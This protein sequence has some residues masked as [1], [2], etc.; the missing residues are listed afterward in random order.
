MS[1][2]I[3]AKDAVIYAIGN[4]GL[5]AAALLLLPA[6]A[7]F[8]SLSDFGLWATLQSIIQIMLILMNVGMRETSVRFTKE[9]EDR[10]QLGYLLG[11]T[12]FIVLGGALLVTALSLGPLVPVFRSILH[13]DNVR[14]LALLTCAGALMQALSIHAMTYYRACNQA[15]RYMVGGILGA[16]L[17]FITTV[18]VLYGFRL[19]IRGVLVAYIA[20]YTAVFVVALCDLVSRTGIGISLKSV[21]A[22]LRFGSPLVLSAAGQFS[23]GG[24]SIPLLSYF[25]GLEAVA[26]YSLGYKLATVLAIAVVLPFQLAFQP[27]LFANLKNVEIRAQAARLLTYF[28]LTITYTSIVLVLA[29][30]LL[31]PLIAPPQYASAFLVILFIVPGQA[32]LGL[33]YFG[34]TIL[35]AVQKTHV[36]AILNSVCAVGCVGLSCMLIPVWGWYGAALAT[37]FSLIMVDVTEIIIGAREFRMTKDLEWKRMGVTGTVFLAFLMVFFLLHGAGYVEFY[38]VGVT[39]LLASLAVLGFGPFLSA[40]EKTLLRSAAGRIRSQILARKPSL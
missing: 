16:A 28:L 4:V 9:Y 23:I 36:L 12:T 34:E 7:H 25:V 8:L 10:N 20:S 26:I 18:I 30:R 31:L 22:L 3:F 32:L 2:K 24:A 1:L 14:E 15:A 39:F 33:H 29:C 6:Y 27:F 37:N 17:L 38:T 21:P 19:G 40:Q 11:T 13:Q 5:R 35:S